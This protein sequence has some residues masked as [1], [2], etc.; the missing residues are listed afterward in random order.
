[1]SKNHKNLTLPFYHPSPPPG[2]QLVG[3]FDESH[4]QLRLGGGKAST[5]DKLK[6]LIR[7]LAAATFGVFLFYAT[8]S[9]WTHTSLGRLGGTPSFP[10]MLIATTVSHV[11]L[12]YIRFMS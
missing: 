5:W 11:G 7:A 10:S 8:L 1:M 9:V 6:P 3:P 4:V 12:A 2:I